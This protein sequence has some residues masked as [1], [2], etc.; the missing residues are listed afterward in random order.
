MATALDI[1]Q[2]EMLLGDPR[3]ESSDPSVMD[4]LKGFIDAT[5]RHGGLLAAKQV[6][7]IANVSTATICRHVKAG[8]FT[9]YNFVDMTLLPLDEVMD[10]VK[11]R[12]E[13]L[14]SKGGHGLKAPKF[15]DLI[16][17]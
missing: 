11:A 16:K 13:D 12:N 14:L 6:A 8:R 15:K 17:V 9:T 2:F 3:L 7:A 1:E 10:Y 5:R 4:E